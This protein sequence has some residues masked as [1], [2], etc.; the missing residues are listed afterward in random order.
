VKEPPSCSFYMHN[1]NYGITH[2]GAVAFIPKFK[3]AH[4]RV[5]FGGLHKTTLTHPQGLYH[6]EYFIQIPDLVVRL[7]RMFQELV[8]DLTVTC[9][10]T[11]YAAKLNFKEK[12]LFSKTKNLMS[13]KVSWNGNDLYLLEG[14]W[15]EIIY[16]TDLSNGQK[17]EFLN[18]ATLVKNKIVCPPLSELPETSGEKIW[19][20]LLETLVRQDFTTATEIKA[21]ITKLEVERGQEATRLG[22]PF[23][24]QYFHQSANGEWVLNDTSL[25][26]LS[27]AHQLAE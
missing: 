20:Q 6:E 9:P 25:C 24:P 10:T 27:K 23:Q 21:Q 16:L 8:G 5:H 18:R 13:G 2:A 1:P 4:V 19:G 17:I 15:D 11:G 7:L 26:K 14:A 12:P 3:Q 22:T